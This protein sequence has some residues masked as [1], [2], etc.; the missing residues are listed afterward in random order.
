M[1][2]KDADW[3]PSHASECLVGEANG[4]NLI[5][6]PVL[7]GLGCAMQAQFLGKIRFGGD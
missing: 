5:D 2:A 3:L 6:G 4:L 7:P 1:V